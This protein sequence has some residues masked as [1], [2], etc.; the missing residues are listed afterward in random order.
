L[1]KFNLNLEVGELV[2]AE[3]KGG[4]AQFNK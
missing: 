2:C 1:N 4:I 3:R